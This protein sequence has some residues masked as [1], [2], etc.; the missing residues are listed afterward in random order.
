[1]GSPCGEAHSGE[2]GDNEKSEDDFNRA[3]DN[4]GNQNREDSELAAT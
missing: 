1:V 2:P 4:L 3:H